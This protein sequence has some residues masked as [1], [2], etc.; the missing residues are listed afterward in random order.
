MKFHFIAGHGGYPLVGTPA[1]IVDQ[2]EELSAIGVD[3]CL[4]SWVRYR[5]EVQQWIDQVMPLMVDAGQRRP[6][7]G[8]STGDGY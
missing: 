7:N 2:M 1:Q 6:Y 3:G 5:E 4:I 8:V